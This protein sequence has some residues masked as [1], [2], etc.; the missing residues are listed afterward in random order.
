ML[1]YKKIGGVFFI[2]TGRVFPD[3][4]KINFNNWKANWGIGLR[5]Y[6]A[7]FVVRFDIGISNEGSRIFFN[8]GHVF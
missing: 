1:I 3:I 6:L 5:Y 7:N 8:F 2:D 4:K